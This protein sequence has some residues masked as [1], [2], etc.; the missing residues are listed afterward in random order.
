MVTQKR[1][2]HLICNSSSA[3]HSPILQRLIFFGLKP[4]SRIQPHRNCFMNI[5]RDDF[6]AQKGAVPPTLNCEG[7]VVTIGVLRIRKNSEPSKV[8]TYI[9]WC[10][11]QTHPKIS[12]NVNSSWKTIWQP[13]NLHLRKDTP[14][15][16]DFT[17]ILCLS[18]NVGWFKTLQTFVPCLRTQKRSPVVI[19]DCLV[20]LMQ[21]VWTFWWLRAHR[22]W[23]C[24]LTDLTKPLP[25]PG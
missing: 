21:P 25:A 14:K 23:S 8:K 9:L 20:M 6:S 10:F 3:F 24:F 13:S 16:H 19:N 2:S 17:A 4:A 12:S 1:Y 7:S 18:Y 15:R 11:I 22:F 5:H